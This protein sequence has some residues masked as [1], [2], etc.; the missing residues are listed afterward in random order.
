VLAGIFL[1]AGVAL[2]GLAG[3]LVVGNGVTAEFTLFNS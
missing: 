1:S 2:L 3:A